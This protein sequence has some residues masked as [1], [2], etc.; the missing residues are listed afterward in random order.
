M[1]LFVCLIN[2]EPF[3]LK[4]RDYFFKMGNKK[5]TNPKANRGKVKEKA[6]HYDCSRD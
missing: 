1:H 6:M 3:N 2:T 5:V 4:L